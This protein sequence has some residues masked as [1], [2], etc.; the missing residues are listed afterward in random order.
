MLHKK[1]MIIFSI[2]I[3]FS[4]IYYHGRREGLVTKIEYE[5]LVNDY[6]NLLLNTY[7]AVTE[8]EDKDDYYSY[9][10]TLSNL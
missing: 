4:I 9:Y 1:M 8:R 6:N 10:K 3:L 5:Q 7:S 2:I